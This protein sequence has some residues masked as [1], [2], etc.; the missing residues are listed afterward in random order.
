MR[1]MSVYFY[2]RAR[3]TAV[4]VLHPFVRPA[5]TTFSFN[6][7]R[8]ERRARGRIRWCWWWIGWTE[9]F[10]I[11]PLVII[12]FPSILSF[13]VR[14]NYAL[15]LCFPLLFI[16]LIHHQRN[17]FEICETDLM[18]SLEY[19]GR[20]V[21]VVLKNAPQTG[22]SHTRKLSV[23]SEQPTVDVP[24]IKFSSLLTQ[25]CAEKTARSKSWVHCFGNSCRIP[26]FL[27]LFFFYVRVIT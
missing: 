22:T 10:F 18:N 1:G 5:D 6:Q 16:R 17:C 15:I 9:G 13:V 19:A 21:R 14:L 2:R 12:Q 4:V 25:K 27:F 24:S 8:F 3:L 26:S 20:M 11:K 7:I 23:H